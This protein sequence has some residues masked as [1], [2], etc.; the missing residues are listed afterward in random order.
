MNISNN[1]VGFEGFYKLELS[2]ADK[3][4]NIIK[5]TT[6]VVAEFPNLITNNG[7]ELLKTDTFADNCSVG[8]G[9]T[10]PAVTD[11][12]LASHLATKVGQTS[13]D[14]GPGSSTSPRYSS[15]TMT[16]QFSQAAVIGNI[17]EVGVGAGSGGNNLFSRALI[18]DQNGSPT[19]ITVTAVDIL[20]ITYSL[21][22]Y[23]SEQDSVTSIVIGGVNTTCT[24]RLGVRGNE[25]A[26]TWVI[27]GNPYKWW[28]QS[29]SENLQTYSGGLNA[30][31]LNPA[32]NS[33]ADASGAYSSPA[34]SVGEFGNTGE[35]WY[36]VAWFFSTTQGNATGGIAAVA[37]PNSGGTRA[38]QWKTGF[39]PVIPK[40]NTK[41]LTITTR[42]SWG[43]YTP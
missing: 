12:T 30:I 7:L 5:E 42:Y 14:V 15:A 1:R 39:S 10:T 6:R 33:G 43:R 27:R 36:Q 38:D 21:R 41:T 40:T 16:W 22:L 31:G 29:Q 34:P 3:N 18:L 17:S 9:S 25:T 8:T 28:F 2:R 13:V 37:T 4:G 23:P 20:T 24:T 26:W 32:D 11:T 19:T 35:Y